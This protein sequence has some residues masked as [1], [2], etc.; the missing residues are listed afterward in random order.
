MPHGDKFRSGMSRIA[1]GCELNVN[2]SMY[3]KEDVFTQKHTKKM[4]LY[5]D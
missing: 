2:E 5:L 1:L 4:R 3:I